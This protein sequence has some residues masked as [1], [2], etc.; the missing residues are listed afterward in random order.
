MAKSIEFPG[1][2]GNRYEHPINANQDLTGSTTILAVI[3]VLAANGSW[4]SV[5]ESEDSGGTNVVSMGRNASGNGRL[6][7]SD[8]AAAKEIIGFEIVA[9]DSWQ[10][11]A[12][13]RPAGAAQTI[14]GHQVVLGGATNHIDAA[15]TGSNMGGYATGSFI[16]AGDDDPANIR[17]AAW[18]IWDGTVLSDADI[19]GVASAK[20]TD[21]ILAL[22]PTAC[23]D[24]ENGL[25]L[26]DLAAGGMDGTLV[27]AITESADGPSGWVYFGEGATE[28]QTFY[29]SRRRTTT[30]R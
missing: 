11:I 23:F 3:R 28:P 8:T 26:T 29:V 1:T 22:S 5:I 15:A 6:Y 19:N 24:A 12:V 18:A 10:V 9:A 17:V 20:T 7:Y 4:Q 2:A 27:G 30:R 25:M 14:R 16:V 13:T 21:S